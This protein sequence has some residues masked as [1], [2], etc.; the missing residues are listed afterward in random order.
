MEWTG[1]NRKQFRKALQEVYPTKEDLEIFVDEDFG[2]NLSEISQGNNLKH[3]CSRLIRFAESQGQLDKLYNTFC[4]EN[5]DNPV[6]IEL[7]NN[8]KNESDRIFDAPRTAIPSED[9]DRIFSH[10]LDL[11]ISILSTA[12]KIAFKQRFDQPL[13]LIRP[14]QPP[15]DSP[16][17]I[18]DLLVKYDNFSLTRLF[19]THAIRLSREVENVRDFTGLENWILDIRNPQEENHD[20]A[21]YFYLL[22]SINPKNQDEVRLT[23]ELHG[24]SDSIEAF[25]GADAGQR[26]MILDL[27]HVRKEERADTIAQKLIDPLSRWIKLAESKMLEEAGEQTRQRVTLEV[28][29]PWALLD[30]N[31]SRWSVINEFEDTVCLLTHRGV[32]VRSLDRC[33]KPGLNINL[34]QG[35]NSLRQAI[36]ENRL[37]ECCGE[38]DCSSQTFLGSLGGNYPIYRLPRGLPKERETRHNLLKQLL[39]APTPLALWTQ[40][41]QLDR[42]T[43]LRSLDNLLTSDNL[44]EPARFAEQIRQQQVNH[45]HLAVLY[46]RPDRIPTLPSQQTPFYA[47]S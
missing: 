22:V 15:L 40:S 45:G 39:D 35:W 23:A 25:D 37:N 27:S 33:Q 19:V 20:L 9:W 32:L 14:D 26:G 2:K 11:D 18:K 36:E 24:C 13:S 34:N 31:F 1:D 38:I 12:C 21:R 10:F 17:N 3:L 46:D 28:F 5:A 30:M 4:Q 6:I 44:I 41:S 42:E 43:A 8:F 29:L 47:Q 16:D 7:K